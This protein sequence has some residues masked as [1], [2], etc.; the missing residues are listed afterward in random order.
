MRKSSR[1]TKSPYAEST[2]A[3]RRWARRVAFCA[4]GAVRSGSCRCLIGAR[5]SFSIVA[6]SM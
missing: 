6:R 1:D 3:R 2:L 5:I 4:Y